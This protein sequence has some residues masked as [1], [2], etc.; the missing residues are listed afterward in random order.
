MQK[1]KAIIIVAALIAPVFFLNADETTDKKTKNKSYATVKNVTCYCGY[2]EHNY[3]LECFEI[4]SDGYS[5]LIYAPQTPTNSE[6]C[7]KTAEAK[8]KF[9]YT[10]RTDF[11]SK[12]KKVKTN[13]MVG[14]DCKC[15]KKMFSS[16]YILD[17]F[18]KHNEAK[19]AVDKE[20]LGFKA[21]VADKD[22]CMQ[23]AKK[24][25]ETKYTDPGLPKKD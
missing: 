15:N 2:K 24:I 21:V 1:F 16:R 8:E 9:L 6:D 23:K 4:L 25:N 7:L 14:A 10:E 17:C 3:Y 20:N 13:E 11:Y 19:D 12:H 18:F 22:Q 5:N